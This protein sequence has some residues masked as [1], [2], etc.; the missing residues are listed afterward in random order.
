MGIA[1]LTALGA[2]FW[3]GPLPALVAGP[4][5]AF[6][7]GGWAWGRTLRGRFPEFL[8]YP[9]IAASEEMVH[10]WAVLTGRWAHRGTA[11]DSN[12]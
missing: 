11:P 4:A 8:I 5:A 10:N 3:L 6:A 1:I 2:L 7:T 12:R 9:L